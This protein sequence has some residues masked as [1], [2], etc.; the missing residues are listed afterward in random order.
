VAPNPVSAGEPTPSS[1]TA[2]QLQSFGEH[3]AFALGIT[4]FRRAVEDPEEPQC[5]HPHRVRGEAVPVG[6]S[7]QDVFAEVAP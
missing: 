6:L 2:P 4:L 3:V 7:H 1:G 5:V